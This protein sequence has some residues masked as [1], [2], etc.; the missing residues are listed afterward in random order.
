MLIAIVTCRGYT[1][2]IHKDGDSDYGVSLPDFPGCVTAGK[3]L[4]DAH[5]MLVE[6]LTLHIEG[7]QKDGERIP[8]PSSLTELVTTGCVKY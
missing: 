1:A 3:T 8:K 5:S 4:D 6:A 2:L 7:L